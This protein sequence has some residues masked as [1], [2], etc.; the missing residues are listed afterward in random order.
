MRDDE[1]VTPAQ[2]AQLLRTGVEPEERGEV[3]DEL[4]TLATPEAVEILRQHFHIERDPDVK[5][6]IVAGLV[7]EQKPET[8]EVRFG[9]LATALAATQ[10]LEVRLTAV[11]ILVEFDDARS[12]ALLQNLLQDRDEEI[13]EAAMEAIEERRELDEK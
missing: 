10:P 1:A 7:D 12:V 4:W 3:V 9:I 13:R 5:A 8:H 6:D 2:L 11:S